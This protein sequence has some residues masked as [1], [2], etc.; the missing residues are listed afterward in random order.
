MSLI[1]LARID[2][3]TVYARATANAAK[4]YPKDSVDWKKVNKKAKDVSNRYDKLVEY[5][6][7]RNIKRGL[8][9]AAIVSGLGAAGYAGYRK[10]K[11]E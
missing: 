8:I 2:E 4:K 7:N 6:K 1:K 9:A 5:V 11:K 10:A 3:D